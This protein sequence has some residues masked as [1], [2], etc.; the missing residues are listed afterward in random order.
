MLTPSPLS[1]DGPELD[2]VTTALLQCYQCHDTRYLRRSLHKFLGQATEGSRLSLDLALWTAL[3][4]M[5]RMKS[6]QRAPLSKVHA[7]RGA[8]GSAAAGRARAGA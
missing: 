3:V 8:P 4:G 6:L 1:E 5:R 7:A 2:G